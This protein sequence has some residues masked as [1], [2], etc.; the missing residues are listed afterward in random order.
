MTYNDIIFSITHQYL[1]Y[2]YFYG[3]NSI[4][5][6]KEQNGIAKDMA[7]SYSFFNV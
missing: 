4:Q 7:H 2:I 5:E 6:Q 1:L 3:L